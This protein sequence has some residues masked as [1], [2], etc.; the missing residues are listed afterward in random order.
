MLYICF[1]PLTGTLLSKHYGNFRPLS[2]GINRFRPLTGTLLSKH[3]TLCVREA[4][5]RFRPLT[6]TLLSKR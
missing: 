4:T 3:G 6:G 5:K 1:R 2:H